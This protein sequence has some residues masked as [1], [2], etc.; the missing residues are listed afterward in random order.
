MKADG[1]DTDTY[2]FEGDPEGSEEVAG[3][4]NMLLKILKKISVDKIYVLY[5]EMLHYRKNNLCYNYKL[6]D[7]RGRKQSRPRVSSA[8]LKRRPGK[9]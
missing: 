8:A 9:L 4:R 3:M 1:H 6:A 2:V 5:F 7:K